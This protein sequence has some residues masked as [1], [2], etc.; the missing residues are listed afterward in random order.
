MHVQEGGFTFSEASA[1]VQAQALAQDQ[2]DACQDIEMT[3]L[4]A[5]SGSRQGTVMTDTTEP[6]NS[7]GG[8]GDTDTTDSSLFQSG[9]SAVPQNAGGLAGQADHIMTAE[10]TGEAEEDIHPFIDTAGGAGSDHTTNVLPR[11]IKAL[12]AL[13]SRRHN[14][15]RSGESSHAQTSQTSQV[16]GLRRKRNDMSRED[17]ELIAVFQE[18]MAQIEDLGFVES[19]GTADGKRKRPC[20]NV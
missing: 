5:F 19:T 1:V 4:T 7:T 12:S 13:S 3:Q 17:P 9:S 20:E 10:M 11:R 2:A 14:Q 18:I 8:T 6:G 16:I 15:N